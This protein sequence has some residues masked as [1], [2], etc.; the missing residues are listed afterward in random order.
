VSLDDRIAIGNRFVKAFEGLGDQISHDLTVQ[1]G[2]PTCQGMVEVNGTVQRAKR[3]IELAKDSLADVVNP[4]SL[5]VD[6]V[7]GLISGNRY[8]H[9]QEVH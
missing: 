5:R 8:S 3:M 2:R 6:A 7:H 9:S 4:V 1:M